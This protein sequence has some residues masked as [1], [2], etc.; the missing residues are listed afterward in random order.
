MSRLIPSKA[1]WRSWSLPSKLTAAGAAIGAIALSFAIFEYLVPS[2]FLERQSVD[3][4][5]DPSIRQI[6]IPIRIHNGLAF[7]IHIDPSLQYFLL[8]PETPQV[9]TRVES[10]VV[11]LERPL[12]MTA[13]S[14]NYPIA[15]SGEL[16]TNFTLP[17]SKIIDDAFSNGGYKLR[18]TV[19]NRWV[20]HY[21]E[22]V[23]VIFDEKTIDDGI[24]LTF[25][26]SPKR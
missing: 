17:R 1:Q 25:Y 7:D 14:G 20:D 19:T 11:R 3:N 13:L 10:G 24:R 26:K 5:L 23:D 8:R 6:A 18:V 12:G 15:P 16:A 21:S 4:T 2:P 9:D 22:S